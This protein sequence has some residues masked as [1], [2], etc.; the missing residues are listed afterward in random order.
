MPGF[1]EKLFVLIPPSS[2]TREENLPPVAR[3]PIIAF[4]DEHPP[5]A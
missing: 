5:K 3:R 2:L 1:T 4:R